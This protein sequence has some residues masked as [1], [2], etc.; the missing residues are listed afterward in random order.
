MGTYTT[1]VSHHITGPQQVCKPQRSSL[2]LKSQSSLLKD[3]E[4]QTFSSWMPSG[5]LLS[6]INKENTKKVLFVVFFFGVSFLLV[7]FLL[8]WPE[9][10]A[11]KIVWRLHF[12]SSQ[13]LISPYTTWLSQ[14]M[15]LFLDFTKP[16]FYQSTKWD[17]AAFLFPIWFFMTCWM[18]WEV[19]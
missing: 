9:R 10:K 11:L 4:I 19:H 17:V 3:D 2:N 8:T 13:Y 14:T 6:L 1:E 16:Q 18:V 7:C 5:F 12:N 15:L